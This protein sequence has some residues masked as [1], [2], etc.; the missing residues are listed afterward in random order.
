MIRVP[1]YI[2]R[3]RT[4]GKYCIVYEHMPGS[5]IAETPGGIITAA[6]TL[7]EDIQMDLYELRQGGSCD[8]EYCA[9]NVRALRLLHLDAA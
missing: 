3:I 6:R 2:R 1:V 7:C 5:E 8:L 9:H 4:F